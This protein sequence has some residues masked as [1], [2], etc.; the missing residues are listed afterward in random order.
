MDREE[1]GVRFLAAQA[2]RAEKNRATIRGLY[3]EAFGYRL[4]K[5]VFTSSS[6]VYAMLKAYPSR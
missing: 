2:D 6:S 4:S 3:T 1:Q 5:P